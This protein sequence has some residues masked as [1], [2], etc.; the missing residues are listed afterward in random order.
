MLVNLLAKRNF[1]IQIFIIALFFGLGALNFNSIFLNNLEVIG[2]A[3]SLL[4][5]IY[6][7]YVDMNNELIAKNSYSTWFY[8][9]WM[10]PSVAVLL[11]YKIA[12]SLLLITYITTKLLYFESENS[13]KFEAFDIGVFLGFAIL[14]NPPLF[15]VGLVILGYFLS[16]R[17]IDSSIFILSILGLLVPILVFAQVSYLM[18]F[19]FLITFYKEALMLDY[20]KFDIKQIFLVPIIIFI[21]MSFIDYVKN[22]NKEPV[23]IKRVFLL[24]NL[25]ILSLIVTSALFGGSHLAYLP[26][27]GF[28]FMILLSK[29]FAKEKPQANWVKETILWGF[30]ICML[31]FNF[32]DRIPRIYSL[33]TEV[34]F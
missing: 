21:V 6:V 10:M 8:M 2:F 17:A 4:T 24:L 15:I 34:S 29:Y 28:L 23:Q 27:L 18:D 12:G 26:F 30:L 13:N 19:K 25:M 16:L 32:Y 14:L 33:I 22:I 20:F 9:L 3:V 31:F 1:F 7:N 11:D 5:I